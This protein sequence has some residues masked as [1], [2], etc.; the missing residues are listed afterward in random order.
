MQGSNL[1]VQNEFVELQYF[2]FPVCI[3]SHNIEE[4][5]KK[6]KVC[7]YSVQNHKKKELY[8]LEQVFI[9]LSFPGAYIEE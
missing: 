2:L 7:L 4:E 5:K 6:K 8:T 9:S 3:A 1:M